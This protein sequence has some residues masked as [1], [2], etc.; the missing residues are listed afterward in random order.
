[1]PVHVG[2]HVNVRL[3]VCR[4]SVYILPLSVCGEWELL[5]RGVCAGLNRPLDGLCLAPRVAFVA[6]P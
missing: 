3:C 2:A 5:Q 6:V 1:M 4:P